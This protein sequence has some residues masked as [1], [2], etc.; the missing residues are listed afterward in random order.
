MNFINKT[1]KLK[2][3][4]FVRISKGAVSYV[5]EGAFDGPDTQNQKKAF[6]SFA[7]TLRLC[8]T[9]HCNTDG[10]LH[11]ERMKQKIARLHEQVAETLSLL[12]MCAPLIIFDR[13]LHELLHVPAA[14]AKWNACRNFWSFPSERCNF[15][16]CICVY[17]EQIIRYVHNMRSIT[18]C[19]RV[20]SFYVAFLH[21]NPLYMNYFMCTSHACRFV[22][23]LT[24]FIRQR[25][26]AAASCAFSY[27]RLTFVRRMPPLIR[28]RLQRRQQKHNM[29]TTFRGYIAPYQ[30]HT[31]R[32]TSVLKITPKTW[33]NTRPVRR[34]EKSILKRCTQIILTTPIL[35]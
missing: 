1:F 10:Q 19:A 18:W 7:E 35:F 29:N 27:S 13:I 22:G 21:N 9:T 12:E 16:T 14:L 30:P 25:H 3:V 4:D 17:D 11:T 2:A 33:R 15:A 5:F 23:W 8:L 6:E 34:D 28:S 24:N 31:G 20:I 26:R 32:G